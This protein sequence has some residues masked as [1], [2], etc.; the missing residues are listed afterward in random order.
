MRGGAAARGTRGG[1]GAREPEPAVAREWLSA[2]SGAR[3][4]HWGAYGQ[5]AAASQISFAAPDASNRLR[6]YLHVFPDAATITRLQ[7]WLN[8]T[9]QLGSPRMRWGLYQASEQSSSGPIPTTLLWDSGDISLDYDDT[10]PVAGVNDPCITKVLAQPVAASDRVFFA[11]MVSADVAAAGN[12]IQARVWDPQTSPGI[13]PLG[14][15]QTATT[16]LYSNGAAGGGGAEDF[17]NTLLPAIGYAANQAYGAM[18]STFPAGEFM[19]QETAATDG[20]N[21]W[22]KYMPWLLYNFTRL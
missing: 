10:F 12:L 19:G 4:H 17:N 3:R 9:Y 15:K 1:P 6:A 20:L 13:T 11:F 7:M 2:R 16:A 21:K 8:T 14:I 18:P 22:G 5:P